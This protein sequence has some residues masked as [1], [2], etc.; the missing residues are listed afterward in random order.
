MQDYLRFEDIAKEILENKKFQMI[1]YETHHGITRMEHTMRVSKYVYKISKALGLDYIS[2]TRGALLHDFFLN[3]EFGVHRGLV[4]G[5]VH[6]DIA[7]ANA[8]GEFELNE[9]EKNAIEAHMFPLSKVLPRYKESWLL[10]AV[11]KVV[12][13]YEDVLFKFSYTKI[14]SKINYAISLSGIFL[15]NMLTIE[16]K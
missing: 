9:I 7:L 14:T 4:Q 2:A 11:D 16:H 8:K 3:K 10:S 12:A 5:V 13:I 15:F 6:P 1:K